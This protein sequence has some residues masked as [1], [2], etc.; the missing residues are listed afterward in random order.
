MF[1]HAENIGKSPWVHAQKLGNQNDSLPVDEGDIYLCKSAVK[2]VMDFLHVRLQIPYYNL[3]G[4]APF[5]PSYIPC[6]AP[7]AVKI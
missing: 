7:G 1:T 5:S 2:D 6:S 3:T 4:T